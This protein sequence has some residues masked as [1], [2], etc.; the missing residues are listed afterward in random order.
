[1]KPTIFFLLVTGLIVLACNTAPDRKQASEDSNAARFNKSDTANPSIATLEK[2]ADFAVTAA[3]G[4]L[5]EV[6]LGQLALR[7]GR[8]KEVK[9]FGRM[10]INDHMAANNEMKVLATQKNIVLPDS[11][12]DGMKRKYD[13]FLGMK[14]DA[15]DKAYIKLMV[16]DHQEDVEAFRHYAGSGADQ[17]LVQWA[18]R[19]LPVLEA[20]LQHAKQVAGLLE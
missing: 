19:E 7:N 18:K 6:K 10:M 16:E 5:M 1:M 8:R 17:N 15:F 12:S 14:D 13:R 20:H 9:E 2:D 3:D 11:L 4:G